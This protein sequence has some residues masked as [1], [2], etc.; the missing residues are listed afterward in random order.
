MG[1]IK[2]D[3]ATLS[4][5]G[6]AGVS[7][8]DGLDGGELVTSF[9]RFWSKVDIRGPDDCW[10]WCAARRHR[11]GVFSYLGRPVLSHRLSWELTNGPI[12][13]G[14]HVCHKCDNPPCVNPAHLF[15][16]TPHDNMQ[17]AARKGRNG[18]HTRPDR[19]AR[20]DEHPARL[21][22]EC[23]ARGE[24]SGNAKLTVSQVLAI[25]A[26]DMSQRALARAYGVT[27]GNIRAIIR[28]N[29]WTHV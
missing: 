15:P 3:Q 19:I 23:L 8:T 29:T 27:R 4:P 10:E 25:R 13:A 6:T 14:L 20:G 2:I 24:R 1:T 17:D 18:K 7:R 21:R 9:P 16:G 22:P 28:R 26:S 5:A 12:P 11:Y